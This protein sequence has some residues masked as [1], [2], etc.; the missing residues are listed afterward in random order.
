[1]NIKVF[2]DISAQEFQD[3]CES[4]KSPVII[5]NAISWKAL[6]KWN[7]NFFSERFPDKKVSL[8]IFDTKINMPGN[9]IEV[10][11]PDALKL[12]YENSIPNKKHY[13]MQRSLTECFPELLSDV[14]MPKYVN[15]HKEVVSNFWYSESG[16]NTR[17]HY[18]YSN[19][20]FVQVSGV[21]RVRLFSPSDT[22]F[23]YPHDI[24]DYVTMD[25]VN[26]PAVQ[27]SKISSIDEIDYLR[28][29]EFKHA[30][31]Y[32]GILR[33]GDILYIPAGWWHEICSLDVSMSVNYWWKLK[34]DEFP[35]QQLAHV[36]SSYY[37]AY[38]LQFKDKIRLAFDLSEYSDDIAVAECFIEN[39]Q[40]EIAKYFI[41]SYLQSLT[42]QPDILEQ[43]LTQ[44]K[45]HENIEA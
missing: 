25:G 12:I 33:G 13:I 21:K 20:I 27:A 4:E 15:S 36:V 11:I 35:F 1:M 37:N 42:N 7:R 30:T 32:E 39:K 23:L 3:L 19:N 18:D 9:Q 24:T 34:I 5:K 40:Y 16:A 8:T 17:A 44:L 14:E 45:K 10:K 22:Q 29:P 6:K 28:F 38:G 2:N 43:V 31:S 41:L 26:H